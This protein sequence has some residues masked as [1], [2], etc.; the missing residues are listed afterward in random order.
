[1][2]LTEII[3][4][5]LKVLLDYIIPE[6]VEYKMPSGS[7][8]LKDFYSDEKINEIK[9]KILEISNLKDQELEVGA[10]FVNDFKVSDKR[11]YLS[12][13]QNV[14]KLYYTNS[15]IIDRLSNF[16][17]PP[18]PRGNQV[19]EMDYSILENVF[20]MKSKYRKV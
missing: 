16:S 5:R 19:K 14:L 8:I 15:I 4:G 7:I 3:N 13:C 17:S 2:E 10:S 9:T 12:M 6:S 18:F 1:M 11:L 20:L